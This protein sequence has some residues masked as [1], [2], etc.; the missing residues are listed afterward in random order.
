MMFALTA[1][2]FQIR[3][4]A[5]ALQAFTFDGLRVLILLTLI[6]SPVDIDVSRL[7]SLSESSR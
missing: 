5:A 6:R 2:H 1:E 7:L 4:S 3:P